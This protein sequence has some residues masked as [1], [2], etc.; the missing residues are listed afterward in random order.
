MTFRRKLLPP[1]SWYKKK[2]NKHKTDII[3]KNICKQY[4]STVQYMKK[5][6]QNWICSSLNSTSVL[7]DS[8]HD[9]FVPEPKGEK[10]HGDVLLLH[11][12]VPQ[13]LYKYWIKS[14]IYLFSWFFGKRKQ[15][16]TAF[17][18]SPLA[19]SPDV[20][21][22]VI[23]V[24]PWR[25]TTL[26]VDV[27]KLASEFL[28]HSS[29]PPTLCLVDKPVRCEAENL[30]ATNRGGEKYIINDKNTPK[31]FWNLHDHT[32]AHGLRLLLQ[33]T[34]LSNQHLEKFLIY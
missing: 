9:W 15:K 21:Y 28:S 7:M 13:L 27:H 19:L 30:D 3:E 24:L 25:H 12:K 1:S 10:Q 26:S 29:H 11:V 22:A 18:R 4:C 32:S 34:L 5:Q 16:E 17:F 8:L 33:H 14:T 2:R 23:Q 6:S 31:I 20:A